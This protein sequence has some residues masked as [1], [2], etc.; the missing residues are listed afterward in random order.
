WMMRTES[1]GSGLPTSVANINVP[2]AYGLTRMP[3]RPRSRY[4]MGGTSDEDGVARNGTQFRMEASIR[5]SIPF[6]NRVG[7][8][9][10]AMTVDEH[11]GGA[12]TGRPQRTDARRNLHALVEAAKAV[13]AESGVDAPP[14]VIADRAGLGVGTLYRHF[15]RR[16]D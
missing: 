12:A 13:F 9:W 7:V 10:P 3:V 1:A 8:R 6:G 11:P 2:R 14:K 16:A 5:N 4:C 15:P